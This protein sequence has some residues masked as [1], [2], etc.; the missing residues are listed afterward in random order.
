[1]MAGMKCSSSRDALLVSETINVIRKTCYSL[2]YEAPEL[3]F[4]LMIFQTMISTLY[5]ILSKVSTSGLKKKKEVILDN[6]AL[7]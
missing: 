4:F 5:S 7:C 3:V 6:R 2:N 1:M